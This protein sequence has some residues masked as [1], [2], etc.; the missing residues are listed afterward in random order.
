MLSCCQE[1][2]CITFESLFE[3]D[4]ELNSYGAFLCYNKDVWRAAKHQFLLS[5]I[6]AWCRSHAVLSSVFPFDAEASV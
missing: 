6:F 4:P 2:D 5:A 1:A 3:L